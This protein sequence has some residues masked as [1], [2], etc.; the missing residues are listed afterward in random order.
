LSNLLSAASDVETRGS[1]LSRK[2]ELHLV[3]INKLLLGLAF[4]FPTIILFFL[5][6]LTLLSTH[7]VDLDDQGSS[8]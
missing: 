5:I 2:I 8:Q 6:C 1:V 3:D 7:L 4:S